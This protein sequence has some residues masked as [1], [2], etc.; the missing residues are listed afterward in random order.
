MTMLTHTRSCFEDI[1]TTK[2]IDARLATIKRYC[3]FALP[4]LLAG[5]LLFGIVALRTAI[6][7]ERLTH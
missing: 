3:L 6:Y 1:G 7:V 2:V 4:R 5:G